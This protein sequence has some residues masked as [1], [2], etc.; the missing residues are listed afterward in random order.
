MHEQVNGGGEH[1][2]MEEAF[3]DRL[4]GAK[5]RHLEVMSQ[6]PGA[7]VL[8]DPLDPLDLAPVHVG[9]PD[10]I[11]PAQ[12]LDDRA[13]H[14][15]AALQQVAAHASLRDELPDRQA[16]RHG[17]HSGHRQRNPGLL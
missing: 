5:E 10:V 13:V 7:P 1:H 15:L 9:R 14:E 8:G 11:H 12:L 6:L 17:N 2:Q 3:V 4:A 16:E